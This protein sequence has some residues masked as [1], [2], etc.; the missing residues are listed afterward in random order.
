MED[1]DCVSR[2]CSKGLR[3]YDQLEN[4]EG[5]FEDDDCKSGRCASN[6]KCAAKL[7]NGKSCMADDDCEERNCA[8]YG[9]TGTCRSSNCEKSI[10][11][12]ATNVEI[13]Y[14]GQETFFNF[15][16]D[17]F[18]NEF[19]FFKEVQFCPDAGTGSAYRIYGTKVS[20][21]E[22]KAEVKKFL[23][24]SQ[25]LYD[26]VLYAV[27]GF[28]NDPKN[29]FDQ[30]YNFISKY[31]ENKTNATN[32][33]Y[34]PIPVCW[35]NKWGAYVVSYDYDRNNF[36]P[37]AGKALA[38]GFD[39]FDSS[40]NASLVAHSQGN[41]VLRVMAQNFPDTIKP[42]Q[43]FE[44]IFMVAADA[45]SDMFSTEFNPAAPKNNISDAIVLHPLALAVTDGVGADND[46]DYEQ[47]YLDL[48]ED[49]TKK[50]G[51]YAITLLTKHIHVLW[52]KYDKA[53]AVR[54][55]FQIPCLFCDKHEFRN[56]LGKYGDRA[57]G[58]MELSYFK[59]NVT[60]HDLSQTIKGFGHGYAW[61]EAAVNIY[62]E[63]KN[64]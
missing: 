45:R 29:S 50:N 59:D 3:C 42:K 47:V 56:A 31:A 53:L 61:E 62:K 9:I 1:D 24:S 26:H 51:G 46:L 21:Q 6:F 28:Q 52:N 7:K 48:P 20:P 35:R 33:G 22:F 44:N 5:C 63:E 58:M 36:A 34:L 39:V 10:P 37:V 40:Y 18:E 25:G 38:S 30:G 23:D 11:F 43:V 19:N 17:T 14:D 64:P 8:G 32:A 16:S 2:R 55:T 13:Q 57:E 4:N 15:Y 41:Y 27:H 49:E 60:F 54:E 12:M